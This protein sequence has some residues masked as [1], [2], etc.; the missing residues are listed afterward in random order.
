MTLNEEGSA[1]CRVLKA[2]KYEPDIKKPVILGA[3]AKV[4][5]VAEYVYL[6]S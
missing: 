2:M 6:L 5:L 1:A 4:T 3:I